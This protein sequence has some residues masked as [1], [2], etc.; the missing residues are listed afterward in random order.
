M[1]DRL[2]NIEH[3]VIVRAQQLDHLEG[4]VRGDHERRLRLLE[5]LEDH[6]RSESSR[7]ETMIRFVSDNR[8]SGGGRP[9][10]SMINRR[11]LSEIPK[12]TGEVQGYTDWVFKFK[13]FVRAEPHFE[14]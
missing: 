4:D 5:Q 6:I 3:Q 11:G 8:M 12:I 7:L 10:E 14:D 9:K 2:D 13:G 1:S